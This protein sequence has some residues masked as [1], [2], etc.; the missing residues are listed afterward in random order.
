MNKLIIHSALLMLCIG[1]GF[2]RRDFAVLS[3]G[4]ATPDAMVNFCSTAISPHDE[5]G[6][7]IDD[8]CDVC[9]QLAD[10]AQAD[11]DGD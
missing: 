3:D 11:S 10:P 4:A 2:G 5:D 7:A 8:A 9:P 6:D 1:D